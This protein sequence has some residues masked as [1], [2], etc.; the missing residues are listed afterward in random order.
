MVP[1]EYEDLGE[2]SREA[3]SEKRTVDEIVERRSTEDSSDSTSDQE[4]V[5]TKDKERISRAQ[6]VAAIKADKPIQQNPTTGRRWIHLRAWAQ[7]L[8][9]TNVGGGHGYGDRFSYIEIQKQPVNGVGYD[10]LIK[11]TDLTHGTYSIS[12]PYGVQS[13]NTNANNGQN[14]LLTYKHNWG[15]VDQPNSHLTKTIELKFFSGATRNVQIVFPSNSLN[16]IATHWPGS[17]LS[18][19][20]IKSDFYITDC[21]TTQPNYYGLAE[22]Q[23]SIEGSAGDSYYIFSKFHWENDPGGQG[24]NLEWLSQYPGYIANRNHYSW[25]NNMQPND[26]AADLFG[27]PGLGSNGFITPD[28]FESGPQEIHRIDE[29]LVPTTDWNYQ[30]GNQDADQWAVD[31]GTLATINTPDTSIYNWY[32]TLDDGNVVNISGWNSQLQWNTY[33]SAVKNN[34]NSI[35]TYSVYYAENITNCAQPSLTYYVCNDPLNPGYFYDLTTFQGSLSLGSCNTVTIPAADLPGGSNHSGG[36]VGY[37]HDPGCCIQCDLLASGSTVNADFNA[38]NGQ[39]SWSVTNPAFGSNP[40][41][42]PFTSGSRYTVALTTSNGQAIA[43][44]NTAAGGSTTSVTGVSTVTGSSELTLASGSDLITEGMNIKNA[45]PTNIT[46]YDAASGGSAITGDIFVDVVTLGTIGTDVTKFTVCD[47]V[48]TPVYAQ[49]TAG[50]KTIAVGAGWNGVFGSLKPN[51]IGGLGTGTTYNLKISDNTSGGS[52]SGCVTELQFFIQENSQTLGCTDSDALNYDS[53]ANTDDGSCIKCANGVASNDGVPFAT[54]N[55]TLQVS[56]FDNHT[57]TTTSNTNSSTS[58]GIIDITANLNS[59][60][61]SYLASA[62]FVSTQTYTMTLYPVTTYG[63]YSTAATAL[64]T[65][66]GIVSHGSNGFGGAPQ[67]VFGGGSSWGSTTAIPYGHYA[68]K[69]EYED[70]TGSPDAET[71]YTLFYTT[72]KVKTCDI[73][74]NSNYEPSIPSIFKEHDQTLC[75]TAPAACCTLNS[76]QYH[77]DNGTCEPFLS[78]TGDCNPSA[79]GGIELLIEFDNGSGYQT[80]A[81][82]QTWMNTTV[83]GTWTYYFTNNGQASGTSNYLLTYGEGSYRITMQAHYTNSSSCQEVTSDYFTVPRTGCTDSNALNFDPNAVC[84]CCC[85]YESYECTSCQTCEDPWDLVNQNYSIYTTTY[86]NGGT[87]STEAACL[88][89]QACQ[90]GPVLGC[91]DSCAINFDPTATQDDGTCY[92]GACLDSTASNQYFDCDCNGGTFIYTATVNKQGCCQYNCTPSPTITSTTVDATGTCAGGNSDGSVTA[93][94]T[95][96]NNS[97][98]WTIRYEDMQGTVLATDATIYSSG[99]T[100]TTQTGINNGPHKAIITDNLGC[101]NTHIFAIGINGVTFGC[102]D[103]TD[104][105]YNPNAVC[106]DGSCC[107][108]C[109]CMDPNASNYDPLATV[110]C[111]CEYPPIAPNPCVPPNINDTEDRVSGCLITKGTSW[112]NSYKIGFKEDCTLMSH[113]KL[114]L[115]N[116]LLQQKDLACLY[117]CAGG[118]T[119]HD[120][121]NTFRG[122]CEALW[123]QGG[124]STGL[125]HDSNH[126]GTLGVPATGV[127]TTI[128][129]YDNYPNGWFGFDSSGPGP[130][131]A[132]SNLTYVGDYVKWDLPSSHHLSIL[133]GTVWKLT[134][135]PPNSTGLHQG[136]HNHGYT[137]YTQCIPLNTVYYTDTTNYFVKFINFVNDF[138]VDCLK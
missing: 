67:H 50:S 118:Y 74:A 27:S 123:V 48:G 33:K 138:C 129:S 120:I 114:I 96:L 105:C 54:A 136:C 37:F 81:N 42:T 82:F 93:T 23:L 56:L 45:S 10:E 131:G 103:P 117:N 6:N 58:N 9:Q 99:N 64:E 77:T 80:I 44:T 62:G 5:I 133:N 71:C 110:G 31:Y 112:L 52:G 25:R 107:G 127:G 47:S 135:N 113:W 3:R 13:V 137:H 38:D 21:N 124:Q 46:F 104:S 8:N 92:Y 55:N 106:D 108:I 78:V 121:N 89:A 115:I 7:P 75:A 53:T 14:I 34:M 41:G 1:D 16:F 134:T 84:D 22:D 28:M 79:T 101:E 88:A 102:M 51:N 12:N 36:N 100:A 49:A 39:I 128:I 66:T 43:Q 63:D 116:Y 111:P 119:I 19:S 17:M 122:D 4:T 61:Q 126:Q 2:S 60:V 20:S 29:I 94:C 91:M 85:V 83:A 98:S 109:G 59:T 73:T 132:F 95:L 32:N 15:I 125:N 11:A 76:I 87:Y 35:F 40:T 86:P 90:C 24:I 72:V 130:G 68:I 70:S 97:T 30:I 26:W 69:V 57:I 65:K 18:Q